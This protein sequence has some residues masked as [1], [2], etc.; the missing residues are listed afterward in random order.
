MTL[1]DALMLARHVDANLPG[2]EVVAVGRFVPVP[3]WADATPWKVS[4]WS[5]RLQKVS[6]VESD[7]EMRALVERVHEQSQ[8]ELGMLF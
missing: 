3:T 6:I 2:F 4:V 1:E 7:A 8:R 5:G